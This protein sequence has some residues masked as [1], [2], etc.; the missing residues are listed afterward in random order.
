M[1]KAGH[2]FTSPGFAKW[3]NHL[4]KWCFGSF[5]SP[6]SE[7]LSCEVYIPC[8]P[9][10]ELGL[11]FNEWTLMDLEADGRQLPW[12]EARDLGEDSS[13]ASLTIPYFG[14]EKWGLFRVCFY[15]L[16]AEIRWGVGP[17]H[18]ESLDASVWAWAVGQ[19][20]YGSASGGVSYG[21]N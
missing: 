14:R 16:V 18:P 15:L 4:T 11:L 6:M 8:K 13:T 7:A 19:M 12:E 10:Q 1:E 3:I 9:C 2:V 21:F 20:D 5:L 17:P